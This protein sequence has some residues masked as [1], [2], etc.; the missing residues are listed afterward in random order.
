VRTN[1]EEVAAMARCEVCDND[2][3]K[4]FEVRMNGRA[5]V[6]DCFECAVHALAPECARC[7]CRVVGHGVEEDGAIYCGAHCAKASGANEVRDRA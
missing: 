6:F 4:S 7:D 3:D 1:G 2:Y 5:H